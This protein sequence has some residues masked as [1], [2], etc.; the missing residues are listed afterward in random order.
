VLQLE[1]PVQINNFLRKAI[2]PLGTNLKHTV[3]NMRQGEAQYMRKAGGFR[4]ECEG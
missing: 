2:I 1:H 4:G 3:T